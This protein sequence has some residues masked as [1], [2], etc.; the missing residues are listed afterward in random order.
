MCVCVGPSVKHLDVAVL[1]RRPSVPIATY[2]FV[3]TPCKHVFCVCVCVCVCVAEPFPKL[4]VR[5]V[6]V[7]E[8]SDCHSVLLWRK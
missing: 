2:H 3:I 5:T 8:I 7:S 4:A 6:M 1:Q